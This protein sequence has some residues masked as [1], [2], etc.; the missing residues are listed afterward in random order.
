MIGRVLFQSAVIRRLLLAAAIGALAPSAPAAF[1][2]ERPIGV[3]LAAGDIAGCSFFGRH[4]AAAT[5]RVITGEIAAASRAGLPVRVLALGDLAYDRGSKEDF[6]CFDRSWGAFKSLLLPVPG[7]HEY[8]N[9]P[10]SDAAPYFEYFLDNPLVSENGPRAGYF[11]FG[12]PGPDAP[13]RLIA[14]NAYLRGEDAKRQQEWLARTLAETRSPCILAF[15]HPFL[16]SSGYRGHRNDASREPEPLADL[17]PAFRL[18]HARGATLLLTAH[19][20][21]FEQ[22]APHDPQGKTDEAG[23]RSF[24]V[25]TGGEALYES[26]RRTYWKSTE[27]FSDRTH[28]VLKLTLY[29]GRYEWALL[30]V[31]GDQPLHLPVTRD[32]CLSRTP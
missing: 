19:D 31:A 25:G 9:S 1:A 27:A 14:L 2:D 5:A 23:V 6:A 15:A 20:H 11:A 7:N 24:V 28:G 4:R 12:F 29:P 32:V 21:D 26:R 10:A 22:F 18:L 17:L 30:P 16:L 13:W 3:L 8:G